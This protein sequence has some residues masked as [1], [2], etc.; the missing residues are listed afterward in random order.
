VEPKRRKLLWVERPNFL[1]WACSDC[2]WAFNPLGPLVG[3]SIDE[4]KRHY[5][6]QR[7][8]EFTS[9]VCAQYPRSTSH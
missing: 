9:H 5:E 8:R 3:E 4:M 7:D 2:A 6:Q 1:G